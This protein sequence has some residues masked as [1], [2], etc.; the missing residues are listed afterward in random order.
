MKNFFCGFVIFCMVMCFGVSSAL[1][2]A[3]RATPTRAQ[4]KARQASLNNKAGL[5]QQSDA[6]GDKGAGLPLTT[7][8]KLP[9]DK[10]LILQASLNE[11]GHQCQRSGF[12]GKKTVRALKRYQR[13]QGLEVTGQLD[14]QTLQKLKIYDKVTKGIDKQKIIIKE[15]KKIK[16]FRK[17]QEVLYP[18]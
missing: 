13:A 9:K 11:A 2:E 18:D 15:K 14:K 6:K 17:R 7:Q 10:I 3:L 8:F 12:L 16:G 1:A 5:V 4:L